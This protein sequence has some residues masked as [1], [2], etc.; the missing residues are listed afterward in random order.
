[1]NSKQNNSIMNSEDTADFKQYIKGFNVGYTLSK[2]DP[3]FLMSIL[4]RSASVKSS[5]NFGL[6]QGKKEHDREKL[7]DQLKKSQASKSREREN[8]R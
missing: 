1:M 2:H 5:Y 7:L 6:L 3:Q 4:N 8:E